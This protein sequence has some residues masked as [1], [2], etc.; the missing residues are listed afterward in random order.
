[1]TWNMARKTDLSTG[2]SGTTGTT[3]AAT[4]AGTNVSN[5]EVYIH[6]TSTTK[7]GDENAQELHSFST[8]GAV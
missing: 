1:M 4:A 7:G 3:T 2:I 6:G 5:L 8:S